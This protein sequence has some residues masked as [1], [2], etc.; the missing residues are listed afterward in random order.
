MW[1]SL[2]PWMRSFFRLSN[3]FSWIIVHPSIKWFLCLFFIL[4]WMEIRLKSTDS[5]II[6]RKRSHVF[7]I[8]FDWNLI[9]SGDLVVVVKISNMGIDSLM[10]HFSLVS[11]QWRITTHIDIFVSLLLKSKCPPIISVQQSIHSFLTW[12]W[13]YLACFIMANFMRCRVLISITFRREII[14]HW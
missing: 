2:L 3:L 14:F 12:F 10:T 6:H 11:A 7:W 5:H 8:R 4:I 13:N 9:I 1:F